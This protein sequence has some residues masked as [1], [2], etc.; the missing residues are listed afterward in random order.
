MS[1]LRAQTPI[2]LRRPFLS[3]ANAIINCRMGHEVNL[4]GHDKRSQ[5]LQLKKPTCKIRDQTF[6]VNFVENN[7]DEESEGIEM[8]LCFLM[9]YLRMNAIILMRKFQLRSVIVI[10]F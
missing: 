5:C 4:W 7:C 3:T 1:N 9:N 10:N 6:E 8:S 2:I